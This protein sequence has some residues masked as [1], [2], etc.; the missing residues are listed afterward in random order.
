MG[1]ALR[2]EGKLEKAIAAF[3]KRALS[4]LILP[5]LITTWALPLKIKVS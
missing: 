5:K 1:N 2:N 4:N 3:K